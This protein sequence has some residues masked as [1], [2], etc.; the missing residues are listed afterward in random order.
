[1]E[2]WFHQ[3]SNPHKIKNLLTYLLTYT[4][5]MLNYKYLTSAGIM[6]FLKCTRIG[7]CD[8]VMKLITFFHFLSF[9]GERM[10]S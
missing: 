3:M 6:H 9:N 8:E 7:K 10:R 1:M 5:H 4:K 2:D